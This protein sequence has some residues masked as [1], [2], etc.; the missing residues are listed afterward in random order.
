MRS[1]S[2]VKRHRKKIIV[3]LAS[4]GDLAFL[5]IMFF[6]LTSTFIKEAPLELTPP[7]SRDIERIEDSQISV[8]IDQDGKIYLQGVEM[9]NPEA[10]EWGLTGLLENIADEADR[11]VVFRC[12]RDAP[13]AVFEPVIAAIAEAGGRIVAIGELNESLQP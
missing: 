7:D 6:M 4:I 1:R 8:S 3:P 13:K 2:F 10:V 11:L 9:A 12:D 5:L